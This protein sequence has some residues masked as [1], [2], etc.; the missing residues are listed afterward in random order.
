MKI[1][2]KTLQQHTFTVEAAESDSVQTLKQKIE[3]E[4]GKDNFPVACQ[5]LIYA[6]KILDNDK[7][8]K[9]Y[10]IEEKNFVVAMITK[11]K[12]PSA[13]TSDEKPQATTP[14]E[15]V[16]APSIADTP[17]PVSATSEGDASAAAAETEEAPNTST[18]QAAAGTEQVSASSF[19]SGSTLEDN[20]K[21]LMAMGFEREKVLA[22]LRASFYNPDRAVE[23]LVSGE[24]IPVPTEEAPPAAQAP[25][26]GAP[27][28]AAPVTPAPATGGSNPLEFLREQP[29]FQR[30]CEVLQ[31]N[32][33]LLPGLL[34]E[35]QQSNPELL[36]RISQNQ[37]D[38]IE[39]INSSVQA[40]GGTGTGTTTAQPTAPPP[41]TQYIEVTTED[42]AAVDRLKALGQFSES[43]VLQIYIACDRNETAAANILFENQD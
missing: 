40:R 7:T 35:L 17:A 9:D 12:T 5:K 36:A 4:K 20:V 42:K 22:A 26:S 3:D 32:P 30:M 13:S 34:Q 15:P 24:D 6:G 43:D 11:A 39:L 2:I 8:I 38:F 23:Y 25:A 18:E 41:G 29:Q 28:S 21:R 1:V 37:E 27:V 33:S 31:G 14:S 16:A 10:N 19:M